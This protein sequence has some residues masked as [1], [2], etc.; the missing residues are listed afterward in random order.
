MKQSITEITFYP[1]ATTFDNEA[2]ISS[3]TSDAQI[4]PLG[5]KQIKELKEH[6]TDVKYDAIYT[7]ELSRAVDTA[8]G[9][10]GDRYEIRID[11]RLNEIDVGDFTGQ[12]VSR[13][14]ALVLEYID[15]PWPGGENYKNVEVR[16]SNFLKE[17]KKGEKVA[18]IG[19]QGTQLALEVILNG[20]TWE[21]AI[22]QDWRKT[23]QFQYGWN[24]KVPKS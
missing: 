1:H 3:G 9:S 22:N 12:P 13:T 20:K 5:E 19:H 7:S 14:Q 24:Y 11:K 17:L 4:S 18:I 8:R 10:F 16:V 23:G 21:E 6:T 15:K 2:G